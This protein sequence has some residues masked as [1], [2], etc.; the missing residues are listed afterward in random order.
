MLLVLQKVIKGGALDSELNL[1]FK[2][3]KIYLVLYLKMQNC[4]HL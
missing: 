3:I 2:N 4:C 1:D